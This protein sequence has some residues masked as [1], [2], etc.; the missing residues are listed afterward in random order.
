MSLRRPAATL[1]LATFLIVWGLITHGTYAGS[2]D[3][4]HYLMIARSLAFDGDVDLGNDYADPANLVGG[5]TATPEAH[6][7]PGRGGVPRPV[8]DI[9][10]PL[11]AAPLVRLMYPLA[12]WVD[13][14]APDGWMERAK[15]N[16]SLLLRHQLSLVM[17]LVAGWVAIEIWKALRRAGLPPREAFWWALLTTASPPIL[18]YSFLFFTE[19]IAAL[20]GLICVRQICEPER[21]TG[22]WLLTGVLTAWLTV[23]HTRNGPISLA[24]AVIAVSRHW[25]RWR[26]LVPFVA[27]ITVIA[28]FRTGVHWYFWGTLFVNDHARIG[29][30]GDATEMLGE[31][32]VRASGIFF[33]QEFG[34]LALAPIY[35]LALP[36]LLNLWRRAPDM[37]RPLSIVAGVAIGSIVV[38]MINPYGFVGG[39]S[40]APRFLVPII[41]LLAVAVPF[42]ARGATGMRRVF[43]LALVA[44]QIAIDLVV[45]NEPK[46]LWDNADGVSAVTQALPLLQRLYAVLPTWHGSTPS[47]WPFVFGAVLTGAI[48][49]WLE[50]RQS[51][52]CGRSARTR[53]DT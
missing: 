21:T 22:G 7:R 32:L 50:Q 52:P 12:L 9:G 6:L 37:A 25:P 24:L 3:E 28:V 38:P 45:W 1:G 19:L 47:V 4:L 51:S 23:V 42:G 40:P 8:H 48:T 29:G 2:G 39:W 34:L 13:R 15:L 10:L 5:G 27:G 18:S 36:G 20:I 26:Q 43:V 49:L 35:L 53:A 11:M 31:S 41:P 17:A 16:A 33:D 14:A 46:V 30:I 44:L